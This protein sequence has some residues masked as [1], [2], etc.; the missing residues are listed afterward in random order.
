MLLPRT[1]KVTVAAVVTLVSINPVAVAEEIAQAVHIEADIP[2]SCYSADVGFGS[3]WMMSGGFLDRID[4]NDNSIKRVPVKGLQSWHSSVAVGEG[5]V[6]LLDGRTMLYKIDPQKEQVLKEIR[7]GL[8]ASGSNAWGLGVGEGAVW[9][10]PIPDGKTLTR[11]SATSG[12]EEATIP[13][14]SRSSAVLVGFGSAWVSGTGNDELYR[15]DPS[16]NQIAATIELRDRPR[17]LTAGE[18]T[19]WVFNEGDGTVQ[20]IDGRSGKQVATIETDIAG[21]AA[22]TV[23][24]GFAWV[25]TQMGDIVQ[26]DPRTNTVHGKFKGA[27]DALAINYVGNSLW[28]CGGSTYRLKPPK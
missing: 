6:W 4:L 1:F 18:G 24:G 28:I 23:G 5:A 13:L 11:Y 22:I 8:D 27:P 16:T 7:A 2:G 3:F 20:R 26:I 19:V 14:P 15:I 10:I 12:T 21:R 9:V 25:N 17:A